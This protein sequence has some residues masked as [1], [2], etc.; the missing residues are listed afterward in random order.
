MKSQI[1][2]SFSVTVFITFIICLFAC[3]ALAEPDQ[4]YSI[5]NTKEDFESKTFSLPASLQQIGEEA[6]EGTAAEVIIMQNAVTTIADQAFANMPNLREAYLPDSVNL[7]ANDVF[8]GTSDLTVYG[9]KGSFAQA[10]AKKRGLPFSVRDIWTRMEIRHL[11]IEYVIWILLPALFLP[12]LAEQEKQLR[13]RKRVWTVEYMAMNYR[14]RADLFVR[15][16]CF[17]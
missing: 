13:R 16:L 2:T 4:S 6:F 5:S 14:K 10:W 1:R 7:I 3:I 15:N 8:A 17:P 11:P 9:K 12:W